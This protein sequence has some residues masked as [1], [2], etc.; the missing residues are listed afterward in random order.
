[1]TA[2]EIASSLGARKYR[3]YYK[4]HCPVHGRGGGDSDPSLVIRELHGKVMMHCF[5]G[6]NTEDI[7]HSLGLRWSDLNYLSAPDWKPG[8][9]LPPPPVPR[10]KKDYGKIIAVYPYRDASGAIV[11]EKVRFEKKMFL[12]RRPLPSGGWDWKTNQKELPL[13]ALPDVVRSRTVFIV[14][15]EKD[16]DNLKSALPPDKTEHIAVTTAPNG[17]ASW[18]HRY[19][20]H[21]K[22]KYIW[23]VPDSDAAGSSYA[24]MILRDIRPVAR[25]VFVLS[26]APAK[27]IS[28][29]LADHTIEEFFNMAKLL[30]EEQCR[31]TRKQNQS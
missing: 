24:D 13:Y 17:A 26:V 22:G 4:A 11:A 12:W 18:R 7:L 28:D 2:R 23:I 6:C 21:L 1:M 31:I 14:E 10:K 29:F 25:S 9:V 16:A 19:R 15:G 5:A 3:S 27:D 8:I 20:Q 30:K